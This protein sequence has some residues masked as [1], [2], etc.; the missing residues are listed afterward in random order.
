M[1]RPLTA[2]IAAF[3]LAL[4]YF[5][6]LHAA[7]ARL[8]DPDGYFHIRF[9]SLGP[10]AWSAR[11]FR[12]MP[13]GIF[14]NGRWV[15]HQLLFH[16]LLWPFTLALPLLTA[17]HV[18]AAV[19][20]AAA[21]GVWTLALARA[22]VPNSIVWSVVLLASS[23]FFVDRMMMPRTQSLSVALFF[24]G[25]MFSFDPMRKMWKIGVLG[26]VFAWSY[27][28]C[29]LLV[30]VLL[31]VGGTNRTLR[32]AIAALIGVSAG[33]LVHPQAPQTV[34]YFIE[35]AVLKVANTTGQAVGAEWQPVDPA[36]WIIHLAPILLLGLIASLRRPARPAADTVAMGLVTL[37]W[38]IASFFAVKWLEYAVPFA[39]FTTAMF[40]RDQRW[41]AWPTLLL[42]PQLMFN[43]A[44]VLAHLDATVP[45]VGRLAGVAGHLP[46]DDCR[47]F[48][49]D[50]SDFSELFFY[51]PQCSYTVGLDPHFLSE[52]EPRRAELV[53]DALAGRVV[54]VGDLAE[55]LFDSRWIVVTNTALLRRAAS[56]PRLVKVYEDDGGSL[57]RVASPAAGN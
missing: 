20:A 51:A 14:S 6:W 47:V 23:R 27:H 43:G 34:I 19:L 16:S 46:A 35:H 57:W 13:F 22:G 53:E 11:D 26:F 52:A 4:A 25:V 3:A 28:V 49:A 24:L 29:V 38:L 7:D 17:A 32:P 30:P 39:V 10:R 33:F 2:A 50:W 12:W 21:V 54:R 44:Q 48:N 42:A 8:A 15:D 37:A 36:T 40:W 5:G 55:H 56:D 31:I 18:S 41:S 9:A 1:H 45:P